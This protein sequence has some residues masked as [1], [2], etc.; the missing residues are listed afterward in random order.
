M[1]FSGISNT[2]ILGKALRFPLRLIPPSAVLPI[3]Q[4]PLRGKK[5]I[6]G[7]SSHGCWVGSF[8]YEKQHAFAQA[9]A[10]GDVVYDLGANVGFYSLLASVLVGSTGRVYSF[11][12]L[13][14]NIAY[15]KRH[16]ALNHMSNC[17]VLEIAV[18]DA[19]GEARFDPSHEPTMAR[20]SSRGNTMVRT[21]RLDS[22]VSQGEI[23]APNMMKIDIEGSEMDALKGCA[24]TIE[25]HRPTIVLATHGAEVHQACVQFLRVRDYRLES[26][27]PDTVETSAELIARPNA[28]R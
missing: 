3:L 17:Q 7:S 11:E 26:L 19:D 25:R 13:P 8:E 23:S 16:V 1:N 2:T 10:A 6:V 15:L 4:G 21:M 22:L 12:P 24:E 9:V 5:W 27:T 18:S 14:R 20:L 28:S